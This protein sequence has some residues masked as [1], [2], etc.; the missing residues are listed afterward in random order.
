[1][2]ETKTTRG[3][4]GIAD[5]LTPTRKAR[6]LGVS[7]CPSAL[8]KTLGRE[9]SQE[10]PTQ[11]NTRSQLSASPIKQFDRMSNK[12][13]RKRKR[14]T[15]R[16]ARTERMER[17]DG[18]DSF[19]QKIFV[20]RRRVLFLHLPSG[21]IPFWFHDLFHLSFLRLYESISFFLRTQI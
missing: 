10:S 20:E 14:K 4:Q 5:R 12:K 21:R 2:E 3:I 16:P 8:E 13:E 17:K 18:D 15:D 11:T 1:M 19:S 9:Q 6:S 7:A